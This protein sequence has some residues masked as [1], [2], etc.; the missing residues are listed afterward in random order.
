MIR[1]LATG[2]Q[3]SQA[4]PGAPRF[5]QQ[6]PRFE[7]AFQH[8]IEVKDDNLEDLLSL[9]RFK[10]VFLFIYNSRWLY[11]S[12]T[13]SDAYTAVL[14][15]LDQ[16]AEKYRDKTRILVAD[17]AENP[18][19]ADLNSRNPAYSATSL[20]AFVYGRLTGARASLHKNDGPMVED[21]INEM[22]DS[23]GRMDDVL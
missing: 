3:P 6:G 11:G 5:R 1:P 23:P 18:K 7:Y 9:Q 22:L 12:S 13:Q 21:F 10:T 4:L 15:M 20:Y 19:V 14:P 2:V 16:L 8:A 17:E